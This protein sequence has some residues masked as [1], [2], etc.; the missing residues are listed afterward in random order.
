V[1]LLTKI[2][3]A[4]DPEGFVG[5][6]GANPFK[7]AGEENL[8]HIR[9]ISRNARKKI[10]FVQDLPPE[11]NL[12]KALSL[13]QKNYNCGGAV[14]DHPEWGK[15]LKLNGDQREGVKKF[16]VNCGVTTEGNIRVHGV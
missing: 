3:A 1:K 9:V 5:F 10:T 6:G 4:A 11:V 13:L 14:M 16:L 8:V 2:E 7:D 12:K 15:V